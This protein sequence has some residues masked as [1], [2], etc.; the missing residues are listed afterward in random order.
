[1]Q[2]SLGGVIAFERTIEARGL[3]EMLENIIA[4]APR[5]A[6]ARA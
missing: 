4:E 3:V 2:W 5:Q 1:M 6:S